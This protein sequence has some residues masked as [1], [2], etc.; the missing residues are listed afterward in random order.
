MGD[1]GFLICR[2]EGVEVSY[3]GEGHG[4]IGGENDETAYGK[5]AVHYLRS[6]SYIKG[7]LA[8]KR[9]Q[10]VYPA[11]QPAKPL[12]L[13]GGPVKGPIW[14]GRTAAEVFLHTLRTNEADMAQLFKECGEKAVLRL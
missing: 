14:S 9:E 1:Q 8:K 2:A 5:G 10:R 12:A 3:G 13:H 6:S 4:K 11:K 7:E